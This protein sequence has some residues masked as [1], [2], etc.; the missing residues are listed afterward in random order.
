VHTS[1]STV[2]T[3][4]GWITPTAIGTIEAVLGAIAKR[5][6]RRSDHEFASQVPDDALNAFSDL[7]RE[8][9]RDRAT[10]LTAIAVDLALRSAGIVREELEPT[11]IGLVAGCASAGQ[12]GMIDFA[13]DVRGQGA[14]FVSPLRFPQ[15]VG[16]YLAGAIARAYAIRGPS[17]TFACADASSLEAVREGADLVA[18]GQADVVLAGGTEVWSDRVSRTPITPS[19]GLSEG[20]CWFVLE[21]GAS[22]GRRDAIPLATVAIA[23]DAGRPAIISSTGALEGAVF[24]AHEIG[25]CG[26]AL[27]ASAIAAA[28]GAARG[29]SVPVVDSA[30]EHAAV[31]TAR[32]HEPSPVA[33]NE[34]IRV[35]AGSP[36]EKGVS[37]DLRAGSS[38]QSLR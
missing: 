22:A 29:L 16:N 20:A 14:R 35:I 32:F 2:L 8:V 36:D 21:R 1:T 9:V 34:F 12:A 4:C 10:R 5:P 3:G 18:S 19:V 26:G 11:R 28:I 25:D 31:H 24:I 13:E 23:D 37:L 7:P 38:H 15:T 30:G 33:T 17:L 27:G 6:E